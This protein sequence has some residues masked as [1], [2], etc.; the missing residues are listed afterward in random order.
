[1]DQ[2]SIKAAIK[3]VSKSGQSLYDLDAEFKDN[4]EVVLAAVTSD[5]LAMK[6]ASDRLKDDEKFVEKAIES[7]RGDV[8]QFASD[9]I[10]NNKK[11]AKMAIESSWTSYNVLGDDLKADK[12]LLQLAL[13]NNGNV[14]SNQ[15]PLQTCDEKF[16]ADRAIVEQAIDNWAYAIMYASEDLKGDR[17]LI[18]KA[19]SSIGGALE[20]ASDSLKDDKEIV[21]LAVSGDPDA[22]EYAS[23]KLKK[24]KDILKVVKG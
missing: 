12:E 2:K 1:M 11:C 17:E 20:Y 13:D 7:S 10:L 23:D 8:I 22:L 5:M 19:V 3:K 4:D 24:D 16:R 21:M 18:R 14:F 9:R 6:Y 15:T